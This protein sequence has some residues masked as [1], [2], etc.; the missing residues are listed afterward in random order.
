[1]AAVTQ[2]SGPTWKRVVF[3]VRWADTPTV[4]AWFGTRQPFITW[5]E[6]WVCRIHLCA[7]LRF[8][9]IWN[10]NEVYLD[11]GRK[12]GF[13]PSSVVAEFCSFLPYFSFL[14][15]VNLF[16]DAWM[17]LL[18]S[19]LSEDYCNYWIPPPLP[20]WS[21]NISTDLFV[22]GS[23]QWLNALISN[24]TSVFHGLCTCVRACVRTTFV[25]C[26]RFKSTSVC[27]LRLFEAFC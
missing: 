12:V 23:F 10:I 8:K 16:T 17:F 3:D 19:W 5:L 15:L 24:N 22:L 2:D 25:D 6:G 9:V 7:H 11:S 27:A 26:W 4:T 18:W 20:M 13:F 14:K 21:G 1:M